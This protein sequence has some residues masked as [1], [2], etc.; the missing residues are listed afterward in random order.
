[1]NQSDIEAQVSLLHGC[2]CKYTGFRLPM[3]TICDERR[4]AWQ[5]FIAAKL[6]LQDLEMV[7]LHLKREIQAERRRPGCL[8]FRTLI[9]DIPHFE[10][11]AAEARACTRNL[12]P[13]PSHKEQFIHARI[14]ITGPVGEKSSAVP[15]AQIAAEV[16]AKGFAEMRKAI[17]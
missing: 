11:E 3:V 14:P 1:M 17:R 9:E 2:Y 4:L 10:E 12:R 5:H 8:R 13:A 16:M 7:L 15:I 6:T